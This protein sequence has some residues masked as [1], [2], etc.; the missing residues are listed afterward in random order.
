MLPTV[1][2]F[3]AKGAIAALRKSGITVGP[4]LHRVGLS[5]RDLAGEDNS[6]RLTAIAQAKLLD[7]AAEAMGDSAFGLHL[8]EQSDPRDAG[9]F[10]YVAASGAENFGEA[11]TLFSRYFRVVN[12]AVRL[13]LPGTSRLRSKRRILPPGPKHAP[14]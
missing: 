5:E 7:L 6:L 14:S 10:F 9:I 1:T 4:L 3:A 13:K 8:A 2:G 12:E 11:L